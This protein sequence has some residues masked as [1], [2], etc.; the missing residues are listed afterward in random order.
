MTKR[1]P[2]P[3]QAD[4]NG[5]RLHEAIGYVTPTTSTRAGSRPT[6]RHFVDGLRRA[7]EKRLANHR[8]SSQDQPEETP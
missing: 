8:R 6:A 1:T 4:Y 3:R 2:A 5:V 7:H